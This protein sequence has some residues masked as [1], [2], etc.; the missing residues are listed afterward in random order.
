MHKKRKSEV[1]TSFWL[2]NNR[3]FQ[4][5]SPK[6]EHRGGEE[7]GAHDFKFFL[8]LILFAKFKYYWL[9]TYFT[10]TCCLYH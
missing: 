6:S 2:Q 8:N 7:F 5:K 1:I 10:K 3:F 4:K 9:L